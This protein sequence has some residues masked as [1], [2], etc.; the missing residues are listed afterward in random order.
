[1]NRYYLLP[2]FD[3]TRVGYVAENLGIKSLVRVTF[4]KESLPLSVPKVQVMNAI[5]IRSH[6]DL[7]RVPRGI[8]IAARS[9]RA[10]FESKKISILYNLETSEPKD[11]MHQWNA[12]LNHVLATLAQKNSITIGFNFCLLLGRDPHRILGRMQQNAM[13]CKKYRVKTFVGCFTNDAMQLRSEFEL[14]ALERMLG[15]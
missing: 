6:Q 4:G 7:Q 15:I 13:V 2:G 12:G 5:G 10:Y 1:M 8:V 3:N 9:E 14:V 11:G